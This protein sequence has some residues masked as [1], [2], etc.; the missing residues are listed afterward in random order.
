[1]NSCNVNSS[2]FIVAGCWKW[3]RR[4]LNASVTVFVTHLVSCCRVL[5]EETEKSKRGCNGFP[6][7]YTHLGAKAGRNRMLKSMYMLLHKC[8]M[9]PSCSPGQCIFVIYVCV[10]VCVWERERERERKR[11]KNKERKRE[12]QRESS[13]KQGFSPLPELEP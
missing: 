4:T 2:L 11:E 12:W 7:M 10:C 1:M 9:D 5:K 3:R 6:C 8:A 13:G